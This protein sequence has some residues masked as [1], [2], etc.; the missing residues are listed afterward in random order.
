LGYS[1]FNA[2]NEIPKP[3]LAPVQSL[4]G[5]FALPGWRFAMILDFGA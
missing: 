1:G 4:L 5:H 3:K 2:R